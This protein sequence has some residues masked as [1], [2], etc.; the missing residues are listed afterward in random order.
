[1][2][3]AKKMVS[4]RQNMVRVRHL[5]MRH[6]LNGAC[7]I[8]VEINASVQLSCAILRC[9]IFEM[10]RAPFFSEWCVHQKNGAGEV[11]G[12]AETMHQKLVGHLPAP[13][14]MRSGRAEAFVILLS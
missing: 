6:F 13:L 2:V 7:A 3:Y 12:G 1:M 5:V 14:G 10:A 4:A 9:A 8:C 11:S